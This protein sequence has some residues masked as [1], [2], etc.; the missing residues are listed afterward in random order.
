MQH[1]K[2]F[3]AAAICVVASAAA[4]ADDGPVDDGATSQRSFADVDRWQRIFD[5]PERDAWQK[6]AALVD[7]LALPR[8]GTVAEI[9]AGTGYL[10]RYLA[11]AVGDAGTVLLADIEPNLIAHLR[12]R[13]EEEGARQVVPIL[14]S[15]DDPRLPRGTVDVVLF[16]DTYHHID[17]RIDYMRRLGATLRDGGRIVVVD[18]YKRELP[19][20][21]PAD[22]KLSREQV[23]DEMQRAGYAF[24]GTPLSLP[25]HYVLVFRPNDAS[26]AP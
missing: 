5:D 22:H 21:P 1:A 17:E 15:P 25:Y 6:P 16:L 26:E 7:A 8:G 18:W 9:G 14:A 11:A 20:G 23:L 10:L 12:S 2:V 24:A 4:V 19:V 3:I 13:A